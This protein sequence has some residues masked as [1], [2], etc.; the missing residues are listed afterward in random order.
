M[1]NT[2]FGFG[3]GFTRICSKIFDVFLLGLLWF[4]CSIPLITI[5]ASTTALYYSMVRCVK[6]DEGYAAS[7]FFKAFKTNFRQA[8]ILWLIYAIAMFICQ[9]NCGICME[10]LNG[11]LSGILLGFYIAVH[12]YLIVMAIYSF[13]ALSRFDMETGWFIKLGLYMGIRYILISIACLTS[14]GVCLALIWKIPLILFFIT[15]PIMFL[16]SEFTEHVLDKHAPKN[17]K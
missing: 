9:L 17:K 13:A 5:G 14:I 8:T 2:V 16:I 15:G 10:K 12:I 3:G 7:M 11:L 6:N 4:V 1:K